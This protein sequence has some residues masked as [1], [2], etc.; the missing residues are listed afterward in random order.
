MHSPADRAEEAAGY[1]SEAA[2]AAT[3]LMFGQIPIDFAVQTLIV[4]SY[5]N[6]K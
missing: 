5:A 4:D 3:K 2:E 6:A 1:V